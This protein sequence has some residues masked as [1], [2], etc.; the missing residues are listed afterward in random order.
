MQILTQANI[1]PPELTSYLENILGYCINTD[2]GKRVNTV[3]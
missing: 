3:V 2:W 1:K